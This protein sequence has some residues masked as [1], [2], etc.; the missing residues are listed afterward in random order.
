MKRYDVIAAEALNHGDRFY[1]LSDKAKV[2]AVLVM[3]DHK[4]KV[5]KYQTYKHFYCPLAA[6]ANNVKVALQNATAIAGK[7]KVV[8]LRSTG[9]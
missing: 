6:L 8:F 2:K 1:L 9:E 5:T 3:V 4:P 7:T